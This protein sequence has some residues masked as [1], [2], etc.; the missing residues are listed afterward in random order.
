MERQTQ[1]ANAKVR[2]AEEKRQELQARRQ[3]QEKGFDPD[4]RVSE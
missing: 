3:A 1:E 2:A 4:D